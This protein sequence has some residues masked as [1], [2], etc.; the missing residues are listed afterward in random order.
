MYLQ[1]ITYEKTYYTN[2]IT[3]AH[4]CNRLGTIGHDR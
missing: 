2:N 3:S 4:V 1:K